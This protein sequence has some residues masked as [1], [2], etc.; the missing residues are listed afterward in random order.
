MKKIYPFIL[1]FLLVSCQNEELFE[2]VDEDSSLSSKSELSDLISRI[3]QKPTAFDDFI[4]GSSSFSVDFPFEVTI[5][6]NMRLSIEEFIDY[7]RL[8][9]N[10]PPNLA[11]QSMN[12]SYPLNITLPNYE[13][14]TLQNQSELEAVKASVEGSSEINCLD[15]NFPLEVNTFETQNTINTRRTIQNKA[16]LFNLI[17]NLKQ[18]NG[19]YEILYPITISIE[20]ESQSISSNID[21]N[22]AIQN[23]DED[24]F[25]PSLLTNNSSRLSRFIAFITSGEFRVTRFVNAEG[26]DKTS[27]YKN[28]RFTFNS[29]KTTSIKNIENGE[30]FSAEWEAEIDDNEL[31]F[32]VSFDDNDLLDKLD[33]DWIVEGFANPNRIVLRD[34]DSNENSVLIFINN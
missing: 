19:F 15:F 10:L 9:N 24:C 34:N 32:E 20:G 21:L 25:K 16:Q 33:K 7:Q 8:I 17:E 5:N 29:N 28:F 30:T 26:G 18:T 12:F 1:A 6:S 14:L 27:D 3:N 11:N 22:T 23:L 31:V 13:S 2:Q 4:D